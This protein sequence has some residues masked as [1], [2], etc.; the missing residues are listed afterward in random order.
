[1]KRF[2]T[3]LSAIVA[4]LASVQNAKAQGYETITFGSHHLY[5]ILPIGD[6]H[7]FASTPTGLYKWNE[8]ADSWYQV[9]LPRPVG[10]EFLNVYNLAYG[11]DTLM[12]SYRT[13]DI[14]NNFGIHTV[15]RVAISTDKGTNWTELG[16]GVRPEGASVLHNHTVWYKGR[17]FTRNTRNVNTSVFVSDD[18]GISWTSLKQNPGTSNPV[19]G[20]ALLVVDDMIYVGNRRSTDGRTFDLYDAPQTWRYMGYANNTLFGFTSNGMH[21]STDNGMTWQ[22]VTSW[23]ED[24]FT[25]L[26]DRS[27]QT[28]QVNDKFI[29][30]TNLTRD[31]EVGTNH[32]NMVSLDGGASFAMDTTYFSSYSMGNIWFSTPWNNQYAFISDLRGITIYDPETN[33]FSTR[34]RGLPFAT[35]YRVNYLTHIND[36]LLATSDFGIYESFDNGTNWRAIPVPNI[37][38]DLQWRYTPK[39]TYI[40]EINGNLYAGNQRGY[41]FRSE[42]GGHNWIPVLDGLNSLTTDVVNIMGSGNTIFASW[43]ESTLKRSSDNGLTWLDVP[44]PTGTDEVT[45]F[46]VLGDSVYVVYSDD[47]RDLYSAHVS[48]TTHASLVPLRTFSSNVNQLVSSPSFVY[49]ISSTSNGNRYEPTTGNVSPVSAPYI[50]HMRLIN[51]R[52]WG[53]RGA[54]QQTYRIYFTSTADHAETWASNTARYNM[55]EDGQTLEAAYPTGTTMIVSL[56][57]VSGFNGLFRYTLAEADVVSIESS[58]QPLAN[59]IELHPNYPNPFNPTTQI[60]FT[61]ASAGQTRLTVYDLLGRSVAV[62]VNNALPAGEHSIQFDASGLASG[63][64]IYRLE[65]QG[66]FITRKLTLLK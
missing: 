66:T 48:E 2:I 47:R 4:I 35:Q 54:L 33:Q 20:G 53:F 19:A 30:F 16:M 64:Y 7:T 58:G 27:I 41:I 51:D 60:H 40:T 44:E 34:N 9:E 56:L 3:L 55:P 32:R 39:F 38:F 61:L 8:V 17:L 26:A 45:T 62:L 12:V 52:L 13:S 49:F 11:N 21:T 50:S 23:Y 46:T 15:S 22:N 6:D 24:Y 1:M 42:D 31:S 10:T 5:A 29:L 63:V 14:V 57:G 18:W 59:R 28:P 36:R 37:T 65:A 43:D 25:I